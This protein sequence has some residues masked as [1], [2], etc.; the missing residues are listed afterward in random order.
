MKTA[1][2]QEQKKKADIWNN[3]TSSIIELSERQ[4]K[5]KAI[6]KSIHFEKKADTAIKKN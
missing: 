5:S 1:S 3:L 2:S 6:V 4:I